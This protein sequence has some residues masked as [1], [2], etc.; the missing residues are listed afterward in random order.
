MHVGN[1]SQNALKFR[2]NI[3][4]STTTIPTLGWIAE[5]Q[6]KDVFFERETISVGV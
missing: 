3:F 1:T 6:S 2:T 4:N 5:K